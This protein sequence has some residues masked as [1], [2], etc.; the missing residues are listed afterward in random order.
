MKVG[1]D[2]CILV[3]RGRCRRMLLS[4]KFLLLFFRPS[5]AIGLPL[6][7]PKVKNPK[8]RSEQGGGGFIFIFEKQKL[9]QSHQK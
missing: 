8:F 9:D 6:L 5:C 7:L 4:S 3:K 1:E 2:V